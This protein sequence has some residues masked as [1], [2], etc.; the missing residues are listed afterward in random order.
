MARARPICELCRTAAA[1]LG[2]TYLDQE[3]RISELHVILCEGCAELRR[4]QLRDLEPL[5]LPDG[6]DP[7]D[8]APGRAH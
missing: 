2:A 8:W 3:G 7:R 6:P 4:Q 1:V 5:T